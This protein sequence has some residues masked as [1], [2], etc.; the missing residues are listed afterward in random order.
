MK[1]MGKIFFVILFLIGILAASEGASLAQYGAF[2]GGVYGGYVWPQNMTWQ[3]ESTGENITLGVDNG[4]LIGFKF[5]Y[6][7]P[8]A[9]MVALELDYHH[10]FETNYGPGGN[11]QVRQSGDIFLDNFFFN[12]ILRYP[13]GWVRPFVGAGIGFSTVNFSNVETVGGR[14]FYQEEYESSFAWQLLAG[15]NFHLAPTLS[16][17]L[18]YRYFGTDPHLAF[19]DVEYRASIL[20]V[21]LNFHF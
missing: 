21:G 20:S 19:V 14:S 16:A 5:G 15:L 6:I 3:S 2:Y 17:D 9:R 13:Q 7:L 4:G 10:I 12:L 8:Q 11:S 18:T 1:R